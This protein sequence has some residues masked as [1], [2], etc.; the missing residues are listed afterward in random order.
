MGDNLISLHEWLEAVRKEIVG[1]EGGGWRG[2]GE[3][4]TNPDLHD[5]GA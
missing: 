1:G 4:S 5:E 2:T 3:G